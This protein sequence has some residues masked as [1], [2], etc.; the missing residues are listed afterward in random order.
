MRQNS[1][2]SEVYVEM[3]E[4]ADISALNRELRRALEEGSVRIG[5]RKTK[6]ALRS[7]E[8]KVVLFAKNCPSWL[9]EEIFRAASEGKASEVLFYEHPTAGHRELGLI[10]GKP[11][12][13]STLCITSSDFA[14]FLRRHA[15]RA[16]GEDTGFVALNATQSRS[17]SKVG[18]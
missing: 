15:E 10:C 2:V 17:E 5:A 8:A 4:A 13:I 14:E 16:A 11:F 7:G 1:N 18:S 3:E 9:R 12:S 6:K